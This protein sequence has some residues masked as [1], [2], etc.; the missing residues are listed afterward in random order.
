M[1]ENGKSEVAKANKGELSRGEEVFLNWLTDPNV[2]RRIDSSKPGQEMYRRGRAIGLRD[3]DVRY[4]VEWVVCHGCHWLTCER[5]DL[6]ER[7]GAR[8]FRNPVVRKIINA[9][10]DKGLCVGTS[11]LKEELEDF[12][13]QRVRSPY[14]AEALR[15][16]AADK[17]AKLKGYYPDAK[18]AQ[19]GSAAV[20]IVIN[21]PYGR[22]EARQGNE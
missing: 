4:I 2:M 16:S 19:G 6:D 12:Y 1:A 5:S 11:A 18:G 17:L 20:Q 13:S 22:I 8:V 14:L 9:A 21:D 10:A 7:E 3:E 15:D